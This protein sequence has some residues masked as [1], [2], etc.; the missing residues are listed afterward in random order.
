MGKRTIQLVDV[1]MR[2]AHQCLWATRMTT[3]MMAE[4]APRLDRAGFEALDLVGGAVFDVCFRY[5][6]EDPWER[7]RIVSGWVKKTPLIVMTRGQSLFTFEFFPDDIVELTAERIFANGIRYHTPYDAL[8]DMR[9]MR[10]PVLA[11]KKVGLYTAG[12]VVYTVSPVHTDAY[13]ARKTRELVSLG[14]DAVYLKDPSGLLTP[15]RVK[16]LIPSLKTACGTLPLHLHS[17][18]L[19]G[20]APYTACRA[21][22]LGVDVVHTATSTLANGASHPATEW[23]V[24]NIRRDGFDVPVDLAPVE[25]VAERLRY[26]AK[27]ENKPVGSIVEYDAFHYEH[28]MPGGMISNLK[29][30]LTPLGLADRL[31]EVLEEAARVR[32]ELG[33]PIIVSPF[34]QFVMTQAVLN[35]VGKER[36]ATVPDEVRKYVLGHYGEIAGPIEP[37]LFD[38]ITKGAA[39]TTERP[40]DHLAPGIPKIRRERGP[41]AS[42]DDLLL[43][44]FYPDREV[45]ALKA[46]GPI[47][48]D[49]PLASTPLVT[50]LKEVALRRDISSFHFIHRA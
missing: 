36:Y 42:D 25:D 6:R 46:A 4:L 35:V 34:A 49:Y 15:E 22:E 19:T 33:Y 40:G 3:A 29:S 18:C 12:G 48:T 31:P 26:I 13:Y 23:F 20:L 47:D 37:N 43:A 21:V 8:N 44:A 16:T 41:F 10:V 7:M 9:N 24:R 32:C 1:T 2:D 14:V 30:Q 39:P 38:R 45:K 11:A 17:H 28:Q 50:L 5:L 27:R